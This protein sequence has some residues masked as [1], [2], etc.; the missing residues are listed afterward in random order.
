M[1]ERI[2][3]IIDAKH[4]KKVDFAKQLKLSAPYISEL[5][6]GKTQPSDRTITDICREFDVNEEWLRTG[7]GEMFIHKT[8]TDEITAFVGDILR[9]E[10]DFRQRFISVLARM[11]TDEWKILEAKVLE[12]A[13][14]IKKAD[15]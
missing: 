3:A 9:G 5:C 2:Q 14:E 11:T 10:P 7:E 15:P 6:S 13:E 1:N 4:L 12:L 8:R